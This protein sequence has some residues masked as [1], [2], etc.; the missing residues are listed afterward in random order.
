MIRRY[1]ERLLKEICFELEVKVK[2]LFNEQNEKRMIGELLSELKG[3]L[4]KRI[5]EIKNA[6]VLNSL[7]DSK[8]IGDSTSHDSVF[9]ESISD[10]KAFYEDVLELKKLFVCDECGRMISKRQY[11]DQ[12]EKLIRCKCG[13]KRYAW[14]G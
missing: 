7:S 14:K 10:L 13:N 4:K 9:T 2:F 1:L 11:Y 5:P 8:F 3:H 12:V 6:S